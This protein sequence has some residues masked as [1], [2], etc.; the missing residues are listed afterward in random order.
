MSRLTDL[1]RQLHTIDPQLGADLESEICA[2]TKRRSF[3]LV[4][5]RHQPEAVDLPGITPKRGSKVRILAPRG[6]ARGGGDPKLWIVEKITSDDGVATARLLELG[7]EA[8]EPTSVQVDDLVVVA[9]FND[10]IYPG[11]VE[12]GRI[13]RG[14]NKPFHTVIN[15]ENCHALHMLT[16][17][18]RGKIDAIYIDPPYNTGAKDWKYNNAYVEGD[19]AYRHSKW[20]AMMERR[21][22]ITK[23][24]LNPDDSVLIVTIDEK[25]V[26]RLGLLLEQIF[27][28]AHSQMVS[29]VINPNG[30]ARGSEMARVDEYA[31]FVF[32]GKAKPALLADP[33]LTRNAEEDKGMANSWWYQ[34]CK[35]SFTRL[36]L[37]CLYR[38]GQT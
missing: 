23:E 35:S 20:L 1:M 15:A 31:F 4:F 27:P 33:L 5:E 16:Y 12:T 9:E 18:H 30:V 2:L 17:T 37:S 21:L 3:G 6:S 29:I 32:I 28:E 8:P 38:P 19:D 36:F 26:H 13:E 24:L 11:L 14:G 7:A 25:E 34:R 10:G 22:L